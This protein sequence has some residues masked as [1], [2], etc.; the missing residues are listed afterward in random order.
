MTS[1][2]KEDEKRVTAEVAAA[3]ARVDYSAHPF[4]LT[5]NNSKTERSFKDFLYLS[6]GFIGGKIYAFIA[7]GLT[8]ILMLFY[9]DGKMP[10]HHQFRDSWWIP[11]Y[12]TA[13]FDLAL[14][15]C[16]F[17]KPLYGYREF[18]L[19]LIVATHWPGF[20]A[21]NLKAKRPDHLQYVF[22]TVC[23]FFCCFTAQPRFI[24]IGF[25]IFVAPIATL[26]FVAFLSDYWMNHS[27][28]EVL[29]WT[30]VIPPLILFRSFERAT[31]EAFIKVDTSQR[32]IAYLTQKVATTEALTANYFAPTPT[33]R[34][35]DSRG[36][37]TTYMFPGT[38]LVI[39]DLANFT[40]WSSKLT[41]EGKTVAII[42]HLTKMFVAID[43]LA[44][45][46]GAEKLATIGD[47]FFGAFF[48][49]DRNTEAL[50]I[51]NLESLNDD[52]EMPDFL[53]T[54]SL[55]QR[56]SSAIRFARAMLPTGQP[57]NMR[58]GIEVGDVIACFVGLSPPRVDLFGDA[59][60]AVKKLES[61]SRPNFAHP[62]AA[63]LRHAS[64]IRLSGV[65]GPEMITLDDG[66]ALFPPLPA[67]ED[68]LGGITDHP[69]R[70]LTLSE[71]NL[72]NG[73]VVPKEA[74]N[75]ARDHVRRHAYEVVEVLCRVAAG[76][77]GEMDDHAQRTR[78]A[79]AEE[80]VGDDDDS[81]VDGGG[82]LP[83]SA[84]DAEETAQAQEELHFSPI[85]LSFTESSIERKFQRYFRRMRIKQHTA[86]IMAFFLGGVY[87]CQIVYTCMEEQNRLITA[88]QGIILLLHITF[89][90]AVGTVSGWFNLQFHATYVAVILLAALGLRSD[91]SSPVVR[92]DFYAGNVIGLYFL[93]W[94]MMT[95]LQLDIAFVRR[96]ATF[97]FGVA[98]M[99]AVVFIRR[100]IYDDEVLKLDWIYMFYPPCLVLISFFTDFTMRSSFQAS[101]LLHRAV[102]STNGRNIDIVNKALRVM[103]PEFVAD[104][105]VQNAEEPRGDAEQTSPRSR[106]DETEET[107][108]MAT[109]D[110]LAGAGLIDVS[111]LGRKQEMIWEYDD[112]AVVFLQ[113][114]H[115][116]RSD[117]TAEQNVEQLRATVSTVESC[118]RP[119]G[120]MKIKSIGS[121][122]LIAFGIASAGELIGDSTAEEANSGDAST[123]KLFDVV[124]DQVKA[125]QNAYNAVSALFETAHQFPHAEVIAGIQ[126]GK[127][128]GALIGQH[129]LCFDVFSD[130]V[131]VASRMQTTATARKDKNQ[132]QSGMFCLT[133]R[134]ADLLEDDRLGRTYD[135]P[136]R[137]RPSGS[138]KIKGKGDM[139]IFELLPM[140]S[141]HANVIGSPSVRTASSN[142]TRQFAD[143]SLASQSL[144][145]VE[146]SS[147][148]SALRA[149][150]V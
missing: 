59:V 105:L 22:V 80:A 53:G 78:E 12:A 114:F 129:G 86:V 64:E 136:M 81:L 68:V 124:R 61:S 125:A 109:S 67:E 121:T 63:V 82:N 43:D 75:A 74:H 77:T 113:V 4:L 112:L 57:L 27:R 50:T 34:L 33:A 141:V 88:A 23:Y 149:R 144:E 46:F 134:V 29:L 126:V 127:C 131:N 1:K 66:T 71:V 15:P 41:S 104:A 135:L 24:A 55:P 70:P 130:T 95:E 14:A 96:T 3:T 118:M 119:F 37:Q 140:L 89:V 21:G 100:A 108:S 94:V 26:F 98:M 92:Q 47:A 17:L 106:D 16:L 139:Q 49:E 138:I 122:I 90:L 42:Q 93:A 13:L 31:R 79:A 56:C 111:T 97:L 123:G 58:A 73:K 142:N 84:L 62:S 150:S 20:Q 36:Q 85:W 115:R 83:R 38:V 147:E 101:L 107:R 28:L 146:T 99:V 133:S 35:L 52:S 30:F 145:V 11:V 40:A 19:M 18:V 7:G 128:Y 6:G 102:Q 10:S 76:T 120:G 72:D 48:P 32:T 87:A 117:F 8:L 25:F 137:P 60:D 143:I 51:S 69:S 91:C 148:D 110:D 103:I 9:N 116:P 39:T 44:T 2:S 65:G 132:M 5:F 54:A 45:K